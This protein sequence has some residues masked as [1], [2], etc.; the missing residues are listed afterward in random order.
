M[1]FPKKTCRN[2]GDPASSP[3]DTKVSVGPAPSR[4]SR[5]T[6]FFTIDVGKSG[7]ITSRVGEHVVWSSGFLWCHH[8]QK[9]L[10]KLAV[11]SALLN[12]TDSADPPHSVTRLLKFTQSTRWEDRDRTNGLEDQQKH[13]KI[14]YPLVIERSYWKWP[15]ID[16]LP[17]EHG[18]FPYVKIIIKDPEGKLR[19][20]QVIPVKPVRSVK[21]GSCWHI[22]RWSSADN[23][24]P[25]A[26]DFYGFLWDFYGGFLWISGKLEAH[27][28]SWLIMAIRMIH[29]WV[30][31][32]KMGGLSIK[33][34][35]QLSKHVGGSFVFSKIPC[36]L[37]SVPNTSWFMLCFEETL[38]FHV[39]W[40]ISRN[41]ET[42][43]HPVLSQPPGF[44]LF[45]FVATTGP[46]C[47]AIGTS[48]VRSRSEV[49]T[50]L[51]S[52]SR[53]RASKSSTLN[54]QTHSR[55]CPDE[56][57]DLKYW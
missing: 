44:A 46:E 56:L 24:N 17:L 10:V 3:R 54:Q 14:I 41:Q 7:V 2:L 9:W 53:F 33:K 21:S 42:A 20:A 19:T 57:F 16:D 31:K 43:A 22:C 13:M 35:G 29:S 37:C 28:S 50:S 30:S 5:L 26:S 48:Q 47:D 34:N 51:A 25:L 18:D 32:K 49:W 36:L 8:P 15:M 4:V 40:N 52:V 1:I 6:A 45:V 27:D 23:S 12:S 55:P 11:K 39:E 38:C